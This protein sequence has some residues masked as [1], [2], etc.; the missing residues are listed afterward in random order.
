MLCY[1]LVGTERHSVMGVWHI[2]LMTVMMVGKI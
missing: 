1:E 2:F